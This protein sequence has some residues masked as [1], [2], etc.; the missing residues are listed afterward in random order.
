MKRNWFLFVCFTFIALFCGSALFANGTESFESVL[1]DNFDDTEKVEWTWRAQS[2]RYVTEGYPRV[3]HF[4][5]IPNS[6]KFQR[7]EDDPPAMI[8]GVEARF[9]RK[10]DNW[11][12]IYPSTTNEEGATVPYEIPLHGIVKQLDAWVWG[13]GYDYSLVILIRDAHGSVH[14]FPLGKLDYLGWKNRSAILPTW[15][16]QK[17]RYR[18]G[19]KNAA[20]VGFRIKASALAPVD[21][22]VIYFDNL[23]YLSNTFVDLY[24]GYE[25][26]TNSFGETSSAAATEG[27]Q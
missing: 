17:S 7:K 1:I 13:A 12:E 26:N 8:L 19:L 18:S 16:V 23:K 22:F 9:D 21:Q 27:A 3:Q 14:E 25:M 11:I 10:G 5:G 6:L 4:E 24:D 2:S 20:F 15:L